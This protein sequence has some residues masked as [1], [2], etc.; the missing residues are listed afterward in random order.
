LAGSGRSVAPAGYLARLRAWLEQHK[1]YPR[2]ARLAREEGTVTLV[3][4]MDR[5]GSVLESRVASSSGHEALDDEAAAMLGRAEPLP[6][7]PEEVPDERLTVT[8]PVEFLMP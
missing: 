2:R 3:F 4:V 1:R 8:L 7:L 5:A 6:P